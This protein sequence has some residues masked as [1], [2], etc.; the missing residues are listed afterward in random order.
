MTIDQM[1]YNAGDIGVLAVRTTPGVFSVFLL[2]TDESITAMQ[3]KDPP[4]IEFERLAKD[5]EDCRLDGIVVAYVRSEDRKTFINLARANQI[6][7]ALRLIIKPDAN[8]LNLAAALLAAS[9][10]TGKPS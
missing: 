6:P 5:F 7:Q 8:I 2:L 4:F 1:E 9:V 10:P 3:D